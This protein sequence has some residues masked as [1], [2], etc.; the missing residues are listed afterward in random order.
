MAE[1]VQTNRLKSDVE[2]HN[3]QI[4]AQTTQIDSSTAWNKSDCLL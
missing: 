3:K 1:Q 4:T 2:K